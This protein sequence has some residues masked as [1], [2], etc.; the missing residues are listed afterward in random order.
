MTNKLT[1]N[2]SISAEFINL[3]RNSLVT[4]SGKCFCLEIANY[5][6]WGDTRV[7]GRIVKELSPYYASGDVSNDV[8]KVKELLNK[9]FVGLVE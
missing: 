3:S 9:H 6:S 8:A 4:N 1:T 5:I 7:I 2:N